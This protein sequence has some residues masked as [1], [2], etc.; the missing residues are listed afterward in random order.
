MVQVYFGVFCQVLIDFVELFI[1]FS[2][3]A[4]SYAIL[5]RGRLGGDCQKLRALE[6]CDNGM[7]QIGKPG[8]GGM[9]ALLV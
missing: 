9:S 5:D 6:G 2:G 3:M 8:E 1:V 7:R 4:E